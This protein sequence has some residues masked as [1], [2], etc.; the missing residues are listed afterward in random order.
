MCVCVYGLEAMVCMLLHNAHLQ[1][2]FRHRLDMEIVALD[3]LLVPETT[4]T[5]IVVFTLDET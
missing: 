3:L 5:A 2:P 1:L 4:S